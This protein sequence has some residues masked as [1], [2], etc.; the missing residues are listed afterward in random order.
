MRIPVRYKFTFKK[1]SYTSTTIKYHGQDI[2]E[3]TTFGNWRGEHSLR[4]K[5][6]IKINNNHLDENCVWR[7]L[8]L[9]AIDFASEQE[10]R[11]YIKVNATSFY[12]SMADIF[13]D[14]A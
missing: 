5:L 13:K 11:E 6:R 9:K 10:G 3:L 12:D 1:N 7:W 14:N 2:G 4:W 8:T